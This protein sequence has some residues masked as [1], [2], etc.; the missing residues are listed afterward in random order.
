MVIPQRPPNV[1]PSSN[2]VVADSNC[3]RN[4]V[5]QTSFAGSHRKSARYT[6]TS[7]AAEKAHAKAVQ[8]DD[9]DDA[10]SDVDVGE[11]RRRAG[12]KSKALTPTW[13]TDGTAPPLHKH[14]ED[15]LISFAEIHSEEPAQ[16]L[17]NLIHD[18]QSPP[19]SVNINIF[20]APSSLKSLATDVE[21]LKQSAV[22][23]DFRKLITFIKLSANIQ[24]YGFSTSV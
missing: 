8:S 3:C 7:L 1:I 15:L 13:L 10:Q 2:P 23:S 24:R 6:T 9:D 14:V 17:V 20:E 11:K 4:G 12:R 19:P 16:K 21:R 18:L 5:K 22:L